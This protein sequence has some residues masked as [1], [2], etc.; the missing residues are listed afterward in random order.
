MPPETRRA[1]RS[2]ILIALL[3]RD[4]RRT[5]TR[6]TRRCSGCGL[7]RHSPD[8]R[9]LRERVEELSKHRRP[10]WAPAA[11]RIL[12]IGSRAERSPRRLDRMLGERRAV[13]ALVE[14]QYRR[15]LIYGG[16][17]ASSWF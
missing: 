2:A 17:A 14:R 11:G 7:S 1:P 12:E 9:A 3:D 10:L 4:A 8:R 5:G 15:A 6:P 16:H 13:L